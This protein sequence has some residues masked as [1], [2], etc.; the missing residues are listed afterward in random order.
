MKVLL[1][2]T[3]DIK[4]GASR[5]V[6]R[7]HQGLQS[8][9]VDSQ[10]LV[11]TKQGDNQA[12]IGSPAESGIGKAKTGLRLT[13]E[14]LPLK[15]YSCGSKINYSSHWLPDKINAQ[16]TKLA[17]DIIN[18][19]WISAGYVQIESIAKFNQPLVWTLHDMWP[20]TGGCHY[21][22][23][24]QKYTESCGACPQ[25]GSKRDWDLSRWVWQRKA[26][27]WQNLN[28][29]IV[30]PSHWLAEQAK[31]SSLF[32]SL[33]IRVIPHGLDLTKYKP[34]SQITARELLGLPLTKKLVLFGASPGSTGDP[35]KGLQ[36]LQPAIQKLQQ[37]K[38]F[39]D[40]DLVI[41]GATA[42][43]QAIDLGFRVHYL[44][45]FHDDLS[46]ALV[47]SAADVMVVP[48]MQEAFGQTASESLACGTPVVAFNTTGLKD[49]VEHQKNGYLAQ[50][51]AIED[52]AKGIAWV[53]ENGDRLYQLCHQARL[54]AEQ[55][56]TLE[57]QAHRYLSLFEEILENKN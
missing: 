45:R 18:L 30:S 55:E 46:L 8:I 37:Q 6:Y 49:I 12:V 9:N 11:Q 27:A 54:K 2:N 28:L 51:F 38:S 26:K 3:S 44:G 57:T 53:L 20:F 19:N 50:P 23:E 47:Y 4:G 7:L 36:F 16:I 24:C 52:L 56:Y 42:P 43:Q 25:L 41:F 33:P 35:R 10:M 21:N 39:Q 40:L 22:Q 31:S 5:A 32:Q 34:V 1:L 29:T 15:F 17:P 48:S 13:L 14:K